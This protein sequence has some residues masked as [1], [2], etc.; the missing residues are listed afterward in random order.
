MVNTKVV[1]LKPKEKDEN[2]EKLDEM[3]MLKVDT[4]ERKYTILD[5]YWPL[6]QER[7]PKNESKLFRA[8]A[9]Y[10]SD[11]IDKL[12]TP[13]YYDYPVWKVEDEKIVF[14]VIGV[15]KKEVE[16]DVY[17]I[18]RGD[19][20]KIK[21]FNLTGVH[22]LLLLYI[23]YYRYEKHNEQKAQMLSYYLAYSFYWMVYTK[24]F[25]KFKPPKELVV[26]T[27]NNLSNKFL[28]R[29]LG[30]V[31]KLLF[32]AVDQSLKALDYRLE[33]GSDYELI[34]MAD[35]I[36]T[37]L[38]GYMKDIANATYDNFANKDL[39]FTGSEQDAEGNARIS[40]S[41][42]SIA[43]TL[44]NTKTTEFFS[45]PPRDDIINRIATMRG[46]SRG[47]I[48]NIIT[49]LIDH[50]I[51]YDDVHT[52]YEC[53]FYAYFEN[54]GSD[55]ES[56]VKRIHSMVFVSEM[57]KLYRKGNNTSANVARIKEILNGWLDVSSQLYRNASRAAL[58][59]DYRKAIFMYF[60]YEIAS[61]K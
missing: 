15:T 32:Y 23:R 56:E 52:F 46:I 40:T 20:Y 60:V 4:L 16:D 55:E 11:N 49:Y 22:V 28:L 58:K 10:R 21:K 31:N 27:V 35:N 38:R 2:L 19:F 7:L 33:R 48:R 13:Y 30:T 6:I 9:K 34:Y 36:L 61:N 41:G 53:L 17:A 18:E 57:D 26:Y 25:P 47:E 59:N 42:S 44:A 29:Q 1:E 50:N 12:E 43:I 37:R 24:S 54:S 5:K 8:I 45:H 14:D 3:L 51:Y 39:I